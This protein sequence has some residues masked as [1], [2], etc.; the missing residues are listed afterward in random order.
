MSASIRPYPAVAASL[1]IASVILVWSVSPEVAGGRR[2]AADVGLSDT[3]AG[4]RRLAWIERSGRRAPIS[5]PPR[6]YVYPR[7]SPDGRLLAL[8]VRD[9]PDG[10]WLW[11]FARQTLTPA[12]VGH[13]SDIA[14]VWGHAGGWI[15]FARGRG[16]APGL[17][18]VQAEHRAADGAGNQRGPEGTGLRR[19]PGEFNSLPMPTSLLPDDRHLLVTT[20]AATG[21]D[22][23]LLDLHRRD[24]PT[25]LVSTVADDLNAEVSP[26]GRWVT[27][28]SRRSGRSEIWLRH[29][30][31]EAVDLQ[32][33][34]DGGTRP[35]WTRGGRELVYLDAEG[36]M[37][38]RSIDLSTAMPAIGSPSPL[39]A[40]DIYRDLVGRTFDVTPDGGRFIVILNR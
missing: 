24:G 11:D 13:A 33:T 18:T 10:L 29:V 6:A 32:V 16:V 9:E 21:F 15:L 14:P 19:L 39:F 5:A 34:T 28:Q 27:Y 17:W 7:L 26:D 25:R 31:D 1:I 2:S 20:T 3:S 22:I 35:A 8:D 23:Q 4:R 12:S 37:V 36:R 38:A 40:V 30:W